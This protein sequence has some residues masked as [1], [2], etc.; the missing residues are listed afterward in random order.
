[1]TPPVVHVLLH[2]YPVCGFSHAVPRD[3]PAGHAWVGLPR[4][5][6]STGEATCAECKRRWLGTVRGSPGR[7][8]SR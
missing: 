7:T 5:S 2:G 6:M 3:W 8:S 4:G 1:M